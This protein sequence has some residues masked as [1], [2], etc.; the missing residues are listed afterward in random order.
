[1]VA[2]CLDDAFFL[3]SRLKVWFDPQNTGKYN[4]KNDLSTFKY[5]IFP[6]KYYS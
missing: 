4:R 1:M 2:S 6:K 3:R 5:I